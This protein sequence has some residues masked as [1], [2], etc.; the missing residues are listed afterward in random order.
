MSLRSALARAVGLLGWARVPALV[1]VVAL[2]VAKFVSAVDTHYPVQQWLFWRY[3]AY[4]AVAAVFALACQLAGG[5]VVR[6]A[7]VALPRAEGAVLAFAAG[8]YVFFLAMFVGGL[9]HLYGEAFAVILPL[10][11][12][13]VG[14]PG[15]L[16]PARTFWSVL[17]RWLRQPVRFRSPLAVVI[18]VLGL[19]G[20]VLV[21]L[22]ILSPDNASADAHWYHGSLAEHYVALGGIERTPE[23]SFVACH[24]HFATIIYTWAFLLPK[25]LLFDRIEIAAHLEFV[26]FL[27]TLAGVGVLAARLVPRREVG[28]A[29]AAVFLFPGLFLYDSSL[30]LGA[31]HFLAFWGAPIFLALIRAWERLSVRHCLLLALVLAGAALTKYQALYLIAFPTVAVVLRAAMLS[32]GRDSVQRRQAWIGTLLVLAAAALLTTPHWLKNAIWHHDPFYPQL[33]EYLPSRPWVRDASVYFDTVFRDNLWRPTGS[34]AERLRAT[35]VALYTFSFEPND[36]SAFHGAVPV[37][38]SLFTLTSFCVPLLGASRRLW[39]LV[40]I[41]YG[42]I[43]IWYW[44]SHQDRYLQ[45]MVPWMAAATAAVVIRLWNSGWATRAAVSALVSLQI[46]WGSDVP[47]IPA[48]GGTTPYKAIIDLFSTGYQ[49]NYSQRLDTYAPWPAV[50][51]H[52]PRGAKV[53]VHDNPG[54]LGLGRAFVT[55]FTGWQGGISYSAYGTPDRIDRALRELG[56]SNVLWL[57]RFGPGWCS[58]ADELLFYD[59]VTQYAVGREVIDRFTLV[60]IPESPVPEEKPGLVLVWGKVQGYSSGLYPID[61]VTVPGYGRHAPSAYPSPTRVAPGQEETLVSSARYIV[62]DSKVTGENAFQGFTLIWQRG[63]LSF[64]A[65]TRD[66]RG[67]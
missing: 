59:Y 10:A 26:V 30:N 24:P 20:V 58:I 5:A 40:A 27:W 54:P 42:G 7:G 56:V 2:G 61:R 57:T 13:A 44:T 62:T 1:A 32:F 9:L 31:D 6:R 29:W 15:A 41:T 65:R 25:T 55:D 14:L 64:F 12:C 52:L 11:L 23:G 4:W 18:A 60:S 35:V 22:P 8:L 19:I 67:H 37:F 45:A 63:K 16:R 38:G 21:Y 50:A 51:E 17:V 3:T 46:V 53:L 34:L 39:G 33:H 48:R 28:V 43:F 49:Q 36:W 66:A 47:F